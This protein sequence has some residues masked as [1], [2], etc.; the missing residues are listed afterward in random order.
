MTQITTNNNNDGN[1][2]IDH[3]LVLNRIVNTLKPIDFKNKIVV[4]GDE[5]LKKQHLIIQTIDE[6]LNQSKVLNWFLA[7]HNGIIYVFNG[8]FWKPAKKAEIENFL[9]ESAEKLGVDKYDA[10]YYTFRAELTRQLT[11]SAYFLKPA[12][13]DDEVL[14][15]LKNGT[16][17][18]FPTASIFNPDFDSKDFLTYQL[19]FKFNE[20]ATCPIFNSFLDKVLPDKDQQN[21]L[22]EYVAYV[23][24]KHKALKLEKCM[25]L[26]GKG[27]NGKSVFFDIVKALL[28]AENVSSF[29]LQ[30]LTNESGY[31]RALIGNKLLNYSSEISSHMDSTY[32]K[33]LVSGE[34]VDA[35][36]P[37]GNPFILEN[38]AK[39][40]FNANELP[41]DVEQNEA[42][43]RRFIIIKFDVT[44][45]E[46]R[47]DPELAQSIINSELPGVFNWVMDGL[48]RLTRV[49]KFSVSNNVNQAVADYKHNSCSVNLFLQD[50]LFEKSNSEEIMLHNF[51]KKYNRHS[52]ESGYKPA[53]KRVFAERL[54]NLDFSITRKNTGM[55]VYAQKTV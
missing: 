11:S 18:I 30:S 14:I 6:I 48:G 24:L 47:R 51:Y 8:A 38:Y 49:K 55:V 26:L 15:N 13:Q 39:L 19:P 10:K 4:E 12:R 29:S 40:I 31:Y 34:P 7:T 33:Q 46:E 41:R 16:W 25:I 21:I 28:G 45:P 23:F 22:A 5:K 52:L 9:G 37:Y 54:R 35:R 1:Q 3:S 36:L 43:F 27:A 17:S 2:I 50:E 53:S 42:F 20:E 32:F 44:I